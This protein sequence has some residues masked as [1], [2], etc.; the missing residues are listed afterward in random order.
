MDEIFGE[1]ILN[2][3]I[4]QD[5]AKA[6]INSLATLW[7]YREGAEAIYKFQQNH[8]KN[9]SGLG[10]PGRFAQFSQATQLFIA[11]KM[12]GASAADLI[13]KSKMRGRGGGVGRGF[14]DTRAARGS[15]TTPNPE[16]NRSA[17]NRAARAVG[18]G[19]AASS[20]TA[21]QGAAGRGV[22]PAPALA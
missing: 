2:A 5:R 7:E 16:G 19:N 9:R 8:D 14:V 17:R 1:S 22:A 11:K 13:A 18:R 10:V 12:F 21:T 20:I 15:A 3:Q 6:G 4:V